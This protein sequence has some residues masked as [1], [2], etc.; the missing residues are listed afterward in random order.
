MKHTNLAWGIGATVAALVGAVQATTVTETYSYSGNC[1]GNP[2]GTSGGIVTWTDSAAG[3]LK[4]TFD[5]TTVASNFGTSTNS[6]AITGL[7]F[8]IDQ[9]INAISSWSFVAGDGT[10][11]ASQWNVAIDIDSSISPGN[12]VFDITFAS[13]NIIGGIYNYLDPGSNIANVYPD[14]A[15]AGIATLIINISD[16]SGWT[17]TGIEDSVL[18]MQRVGPGGA[19]SLKLPPS[20]STSSG[21]PVVIPEPGTLTLFGVGI[22]GGLFAYRRRR[23]ALAG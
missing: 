19:Y 21:P 3:Q 5:N 8:D 6:S 9:H 18:R 2:C 10:N 15:G 1:G 20:T 22:L 7:I 4:I 23:Q 14:I 17:F 11:L 13:G 16:P 12:T